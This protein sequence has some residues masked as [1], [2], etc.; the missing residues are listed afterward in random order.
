MWNNLKN[1]TI[2]WEMQCLLFV[3]PRDWLECLNSLDL[4]YVIIDIFCYY[5]NIADFSA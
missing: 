1:P 3:A 4:C 5:V 2:V